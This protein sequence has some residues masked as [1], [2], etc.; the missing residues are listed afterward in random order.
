MQEPGIAVI[1]FGSQY[2]ENIAKRFRKLE[3]HTEVFEP[4]T[5]VSELEQAVG[6]VGSGGP[7][8]GY[9]EKS[10]RWDFGIWNL[11]VPKLLICY[12]FQ[13]YAY[14]FGGDTVPAEGSGEYGRAELKTLRK[15]PL[16]DNLDE[17][18]I[19][20]MSHGD[21]V[22][23]LPRGMKPLASTPDCKYAAAWDSKCKIAGVQFHPEVDDT[24]NSVQIL[25]NFLDLCDWTE[26]PWR[27][28]DFIAQ[29]PS[30]IQEAVRGRKVA[31]LASGGK[32]STVAAIF[33]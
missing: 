5:K 7:A 11:R 28:E 3:V 6:I 13:A 16:F 25:Q 12:A 21:K 19:V 2:T 22:A 14:D 32:D 18:Q 1:D 23:L 27:Y 9:Q 29:A 31:H 8:S 20:W 33:L 26:K 15:T 4:E 30:A 24:Q 17:K 10:P